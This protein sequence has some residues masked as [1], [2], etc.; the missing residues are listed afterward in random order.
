MSWGRDMA[1]VFF[2]SFS[3]EYN[4]QLHLEL[5]FRNDKAEGR[6]TNS[7]VVLLIKERDN[8]ALKLGIS[9]GKEKERKR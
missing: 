3:R 5:L 8:N 7:E 6:K 2:R 9:S 1:T 4:T